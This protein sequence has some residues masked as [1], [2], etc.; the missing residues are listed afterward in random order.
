MS[1]WGGGKTPV[2]WS[3]YNRYF[4]WVIPYVLNLYDTN[5]NVFLYYDGTLID[6]MYAGIILDNGTVNNGFT[7]AI[8]EDWTYYYVC[9]D[10]SVYADR[11]SVYPG[12]GQNAGFYFNHNGDLIPLF[13]FKHTCDDYNYKKYGVLDYY[14]LFDDN[15]EN[16]Y[17]FFAWDTNDR[18]TTANGTPIR[19]WVSNIT[20]ATANTLGDGLRLT[21]S[22]NR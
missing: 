15:Y 10:D 7:Q 11:H 20:S 1:A 6:E 3:N 14:Y 17:E 22:N 12:R 16:Q 4:Y 18:I 19:E 2:D 8:I 21:I 5:S 13:G 9:R